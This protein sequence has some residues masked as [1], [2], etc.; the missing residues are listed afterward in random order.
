M[1]W[2][3]SL[4]GYGDFVVACKF[5]RNEPSD[6]IRFL[7]E[8]HIQ[9]LHRAIGCP[10]EA[11]WIDTGENRSF[12][13]AFDVRCQGLKAAARSMRLIRSA[14][15]RRN[16]RS[17]TLLFETLGMRERIIAWPI[18]CD[19]VGRT[20]N[21]IYESYGRY[22]GLPHDISSHRPVSKI[23]SIGV[24]P[25][26]RL[27]HKVLNDTLLG[28]ISAACARR[29]LRLTIFR[30]GKDGRRQLT[31]VPVHSIGSFEELIA[32]IRSSDIVVSA[33]S[34]PAHLAEYF[35]IPVFVFAY[36]G[37][38]YWTPSSS[39][40]NGGFAMYREPERLGAWM[41]DIASRKSLREV[42]AL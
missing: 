12:P 29:Q 34:L 16:I 37:R 20:T 11:D 25:D 42:N 17:D 19:E 40:A 27:P 18:A 9:S 4:K 3:C 14:V 28:S 8:R 2:F 35:G 38:N 6:R 32:A 10:V 39:I 36:Q 7:C 24:F 31:G 22:L 13:A 33:D 1:K 41:D 26:A 23:E 15:H 5:L 30:V 21:S